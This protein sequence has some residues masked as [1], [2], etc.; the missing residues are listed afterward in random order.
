MLWW[1]VKHLIKYS[2]EKNQK[3]IAHVFSQKKHTNRLIFP[4]ISMEKLNWVPIIFF[5]WA[6]PL[7]EHGSSHWIQLLQFYFIRTSFTL[8]ELVYLMKMSRLFKLKRVFLVF[9]MEHGRWIKWRNLGFVLMWERVAM[10]AFL[11]LE[12][13]CQGRLSTSH[14]KDTKEENSNKLVRDPRRKT[15]IKTW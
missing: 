2:F 10:V 6:W 12:V 3:K 1:F 11:D 8:S 4:P 5:C 15:L 9:K 13:C 7:W 14:W